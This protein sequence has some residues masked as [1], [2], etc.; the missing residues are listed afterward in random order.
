MDLG[1]YKKFFFFVYIG[2]RESFIS[3][4]LSRKG[5]DVYWIIGHSTIR[6]YV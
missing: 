5:K 3:E 2:G 4:F 1:Q 6:L